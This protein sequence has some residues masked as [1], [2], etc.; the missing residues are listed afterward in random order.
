MEI[1][2]DDGKRIPVSEMK[3]KEWRRFMQEFLSTNESAHKAWDLMSC[4]RG[5]DTPSE[6]PDMD[7]T[8]RDTTYRGRRER[9]FKTTEAIRHDMFY[10][11]VGGSA[12]HH[13]ASF[14]TL[15]PSSVHDHF[16]RHI[17]RG[18]TILGLEIKTEAKL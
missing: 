10:G 12:R 3:F 14:V 18:A 17:V 6:R 8:E 9:K 4:I 7:P 1:I 16:D 11:T 13:Q 15:P 2:F 5:P